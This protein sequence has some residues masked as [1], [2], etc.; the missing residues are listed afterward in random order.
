MLHTQ[1]SLT[2]TRCF[3]HRCCC[4]RWCY[5]SIFH[6]IDLNSQIESD[7]EHEFEME[8][9]RQTWRTFMWLMSVFKAKQSTGTKND[10]RVSIER[11]REYAEHN[12]PHRGACNKLSSIPCCSALSSSQIFLRRFVFIKCVQVID[13]KLFFEWDFSYSISCKKGLNGRN[14]FL[15][16]A[17]K[18][19]VS[20]TLNPHNDMSNRVRV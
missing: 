1:E 13:F 20:D 5:D 10:R 17:R 7:I 11:E 16:R 19:R 15:A 18:H 6:L 3:S 8:S 4:C 9:H 14:T 12:Q 2:I